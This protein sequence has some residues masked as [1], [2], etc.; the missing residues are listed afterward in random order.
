MGSAPA[1]SVL[2]P[3]L[4]AVSGRQVPRPH[5][6]LRAQAVRPRAAVRA[7][8]GTG[9]GW[10]GTQL[11]EEL[12][13]ELQKRP[14]LWGLKHK[15]AGEHG[16][17]QSHPDGRDQLPYTITSV[18]PPEKTL[19]TFQL[20][21][22]T[23]CGDQLNVDDRRYVVKKVTFCYKY[24][25]GRYVMVR[26]AAACKEQARISAEVALQRMFEADA[27]QGVEGLGEAD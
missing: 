5:G 10:N 22:L 23:H 12:R 13:R 11:S 17:R 8:L 14:R 2:L 16:E 21:P 4:A 9:G 26:K 6:A 27:V 25:G 7:E 1:V 19:G 24:S 18:G 20:D 15:G 3:C